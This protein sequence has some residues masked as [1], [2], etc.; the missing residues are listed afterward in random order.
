MV[1]SFGLTLIFYFV[2]LQSYLNT[3]DLDISE[4]GRE[5]LEKIEKFG[6][7][8]IWGEGVGFKLEG[9]FKL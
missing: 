5:N 6:C 9:G 8:K 1:G 2:L 3:G 4:L 7:K